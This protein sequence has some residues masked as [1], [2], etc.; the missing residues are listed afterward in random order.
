MEYGGTLWI[1][2]MNV[3]AELVP[4]HESQ[5]HVCLRVRDSGIGMDAAT[6][7]QMFEPFFTTKPHGEGTGLGLA[8]VQGIVQQYGGQIRVEST[9]GVGTCFEILLPQS[10]EA[11]VPTQP[12][13][14][15]SVAVGNG[16]IILLAEDNRALRTLTSRMLEEGGYRVIETDSKQAAA[17][18]AAH[19]ESIRLLLTDI[20]MPYL[21]GYELAGQL[22]AAY[23]H[24]PVLFMSGHADAALDAG[25]IAEFGGEFLPKPFTFST[26]LQRVQ[27]ILAVAPVAPPEAQPLMR[28]VGD[29]LVPTEMISPD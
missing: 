20:A 14:A 26:L 23:P 22:R 24:L 6:R 12:L 2:T 13:T 25:R 15:G 3:S 29:S 21:N 17:L 28:A 19:A 16:E 8:I 10:Q 11:T 18:A 27:R 9:P 5:S 4:D 1:E 7:A